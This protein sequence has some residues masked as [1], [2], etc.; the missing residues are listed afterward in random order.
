MRWEGGF[1]G[2]CGRCNRV[3]VQEQAQKGRVNSKAGKASQV[4]AGEVP[5]RDRVAV[6]VPVPVASVKL[7]GPRASLT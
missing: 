6:P 2:L 1:I 3:T 7:L 4:K 5:V